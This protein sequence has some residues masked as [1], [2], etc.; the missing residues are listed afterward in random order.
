MTEEREPELVRDESGKAVAVMLETGEVLPVVR[1]K[2]LIEVEVE[3]NPLHIDGPNAATAG[4]IP[5]W[6]DDL[7]Y[8]RNDEDHDDPFND[9]LDHYWFGTTVTL[10]DSPVNDWS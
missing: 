10:A 7:I 3:L 9:P 4:N 6:F 2:V 5:G 1:R 8:E